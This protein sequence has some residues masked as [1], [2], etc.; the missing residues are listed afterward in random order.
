MRF[1]FRLKMANLTF[2]AMI[3]KTQTLEGVTS[4]QK[5]GSHIVMWDLENCTIEKAKEVLKQ[6]QQKYRL[7]NIYLASDTENSFRAWCLSKV[8]FE[9][10][11]KILVDSLSIL[12]YNFFYYTVKRK[13]ATLRTGNKKGRQP[14]K[15][16]CVL[17]SY[18]LPFNGSTVEKVVYDTGLE[19]RGISL[20]IGGD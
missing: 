11:L 17:R 18:Y 7:S 8:S 10:F 12:D 2:F 16:V 1:N 13:K 15:V 6:I 4:L 19:K 14:Q 20:L 5:D 9:V 3:A